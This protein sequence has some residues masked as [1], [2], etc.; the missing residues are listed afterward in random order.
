LKE[1][2]DVTRTKNAIERAYLE[3]LFQKGYS[4]ITVNEV[5]NLADVSRGTFYAHYRDIPDLEEKVEE[6]AIQ[7]LKEACEGSNPER[8]SMTYRERLE[9]VFDRFY[10]FKDHFTQLLMA[11][12]NAKMM[13]KIRWF[14]VSA[15]ERA[16]T[17]EKVVERV[18]EAKA[19]MIFHIMA[20]GFVSGFEYLI[21]HENEI[22][23]DEVIDL[24][25]NMIDGDL[26]QVMDDIT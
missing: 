13:D 16:E 26:K 4:K 17:K 25:C 14:L 7:D 20:G 12:N 21:R 6:R 1:R 22:G 2:R 9:R 24:M 11:E 19:G 8:G 18:G 15:L 23:R 10:I 5:I 3:L